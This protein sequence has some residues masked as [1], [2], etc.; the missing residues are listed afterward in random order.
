MAPNVWPR[1]FTISSDGKMIFLAEQLLNK[2]Q[3][4]DILDDGTV[5]MKVEIPS[6]NSP[7]IVI[8]L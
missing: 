7:A 6:E 2:L 8:E 5:S 1:H 4:W 3:V